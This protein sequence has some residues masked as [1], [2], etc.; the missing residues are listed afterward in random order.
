[1]LVKETNLHII[2]SCHTFV[3]WLNPFCS[4]NPLPT[5]PRSESLNDAEGSKIGGIVAFKAVMILKKRFRWALPVFTQHSP[6]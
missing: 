5:P 4:S 1:M 3:C 6:C 2:S